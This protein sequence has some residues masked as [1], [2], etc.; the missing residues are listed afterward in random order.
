MAS[1]EAVYNHV[2]LPPKLPGHQDESIDDANHAQLGS[3]SAAPSEPVTALTKDVSRRNRCWK[4]STIWNL[5]ACSSST[6]WSRTRPS[7]FD[8]KQ[9]KYSFPQTIYRAAK[10]KIS[11]LKP[12]SRSGGRDAI[13]F[14]AFEASPSSVNVLAAEGVLLWDFPGRAAELPLEEFSSESFQ[15]CL[16]QFLELA[17][18]ESLQ[19]FA[20]HS[21]KADVFVIEA[22][23]TTDP[24]LVTQMLMP[25]LESLGAPASV[26]V[27][28]KR[29]RDDVN[30]QGAKLPWRRLPFWLVLR[31]AT[32]RHLRLAVGDEA[33]QACYKF[34]ICTLLAQILE[35]STAQLTPEQIITA[36]AKLCRRLAK[37]EMDRAASA[38]SAFDELFVSTGPLLEGSIEKATAEVEAAWSSFKKENTRPVSR[39]PRHADEVALR[40]SLRN[41][42]T[43]LDDLLR[44]QTARQNIPSAPLD[45]AGVNDDA[46]TKESD[47]STQR[48]FDLSELE[49][50]IEQGRQSVPDSGGSCEY[51]CREL[52][53]SIANLFTEVGTAYD[54][55]PEQMSLFILNVFDMW[56]EMDECAVKTCPLLA[57]FHPVFDPG[58]LDVVQAPTRSSMRRLLRIQNHLQARCEMCRFPD[59]TI[60]SPLDDDCFA[61]QYLEESDRL[62]DLRRRVD[63]ASKRCRS[64]KEREWRAACSKYDNLSEKISARTCVCSFYRDGTRD[65]RGCTK[66]WHWRT[67][68]KLQISIHEEFLP[69]AAGQKAGVLFELGM[70]KYLERYRNV[71]WKIVRDLA[72]PGGPA[73]SKPPVLLLK[74]CA[75]LKPFADGLS[76]SSGISLAS[77]KKSFLQT[78]FKAVKM[79]VDLHNILFPMGALFSL[80]DAES[81]T[82]LHRL[83]KPLTL[84]HLCGVHVPRG[85]QDSVLP[86]SEHPPRDVDGP[87]SYEIVAS[88]TN[89]PSKMT[90]H[91]FMAYQRLF[92]GKARRWFTILVELGS[93]NLNFSS[94]DTMHVLGQ[95]AVQAGPR[96]GREPLRVAHAVFE[97]DSFCRRLAEQ[98]NT[99]LRGLLSN[100]R[101]SHCM[102]LLITLSLRLFALAPSTHRKSAEGMLK[103]ARRATCE[104]ISLLR[105]EVRNATEADAA[106]R[107][108]T[109]GLWA[110][111]LCRRTFA[112]FVEQGG[113]SPLGPEDLCAY[114]QASIALRENLITNVEKL[115]QTLKNLLVRDAKLAHG[116]EDLI[117]LSANSCPGSLEAAIT[118]SWSGSGDSAGR[119][120]SPWKF[121]PSPNNSW[122]A[123][124]ITTTAHRFAS[125]QV[126]HF[127]F[128]QGHLLVD[129]N[130]LGKLP[131][132]IRNSEAVRELFGNQHLLTYSSSL[133]DMTHMLA[134]EIQGH[135]I[136]FGIR[137]DS[138]VIR[139]VTRHG[140]LEYVP[141]RVFSMMNDGFDL[142]TSLVDNCVQW[143][144][145]HSKRIEFRRKPVIW[146]TRKQDWILDV[147]NRQARRARVLLVDPH[148][149]LFRR[150]ARLFRHFEVP[151]RLTAF[152]PLMGTLSLE[153]RHLELSFFVNRDSL[154]ECRELRAEIDPDQD[155][156]TMYGLDS[157]IVLRD[158]DNKGRRSLIVPLSAPT[159]RRHGV[160]IAVRACGSSNYGRFEID[161]ILGRLSCPPEPVLLY[162]KALLHA[163]TSFALPDPLTGRTGTE[164]AIHILKSGSSQPWTPLGD[165]PARIL[166]TLGKLSPGR[167]Y[168]P[169]DK[170]C[171]QTVDWSENL[172]ATIQHDV[173]ESIVEQ[174]LNKSDRLEAFAS[175]RDDEVST[176]SPSHLRKRGESQR[177]LYERGGSDWEGSLTCRDVRYE[178]R[179]RDLS[180]SQ[181][182]NVCQIVGL[183]RKR[184][185]KI[186]VKRGIEA[187]LRHWK[188]IGGFLDPGN[189]APVCM[190]DLVDSDLSEQWGALINFCKSTDLENP[191]PLIFRLSALSFGPD[192]NMDM[193]RVLVAFGCLEE[194]RALP[195]P[196]Y[197]SFV[198]LKTSRCPTAE[199]LEG[200]IASAYVAFTCATPKKKVRQSR[201][202]HR[203]LCEA[204]G[205]RLARF[206]AEQWPTSRPLVEGFRSSV[207]DVDL[208]LD[209][210]LPEWDR[211]YRNHALVEYTREAQKILDCYKGRQ[212]MSTVGDVALNGPMMHRATRD[213]VVPSLSRHLLTKCGPLPGG[214][215]SPS[216]GGVVA[217]DALPRLGSGSAAFGGAPVSRASA[218]SPSEAGEL[219]RILDLFI[220]SPD[221]LRRE[222]GL[223]LKTSLAALEHV[224]DGQAS[225]HRAPPSL[226]AINDG[227][228][229]ASAA[230]NRHFGS[231]AAAFS[232]ADCR[233]KWLRLGNMWPCITPVTTLELL[234]STSGNVFGENMKEALVSY[235]LLATY[236]QRLERMAQA[237]LRREEPK[238]DAEWRNGGHENWVP[239]DFPDWLLIEIDSNLLIRSEQVDVALAIILPPSGSNS[240][241]QMNMGQGKTSCIV[242]MAMAL[243]ASKTQ[244][245]RLIVPKALLLQTAQMVQSRLG[246][247]VGREVRSIS[248]SRQTPTTPTMLRLYSEIHQEVLGLHGLILA[249]PDHILSFKLSGLQKVADSKM[250]AAQ[251]MIRIQ[252]WLTNTC[253]D[254]LDE[255]DF[256]LGARTQLIYPS[257]P[258]THVDGHP[259]RWEVAQSLLHLV[260]DGLPSLRSRFPRS[261]EVVRR[262][263]GFPIVHF[264]NE[265]VENELHR[266]I[267]NT[268]CS[269][270]SS[271]LRFARPSTV[272]QRRDME[273]LLCDEILDKAA[274]DRSLRIFADQES[275]PKML[276]LIR[277]LVLNRILLLCL[278]K[279]WNVQYGLHPDRPP[280]AV[281]F[282]AKGVPS[283]RAE[284]GHPDVAIIFTCL[285][286]YYSGLT[287][288]QFSQALQHVLNS[289][290]PATEY[291]RWTQGCDALPDALHHWNA[292]NAADK[293][294]VEELWHHLRL[295]RTVLGYYMNRFV[296]PVHAK[297][298]GIKLQASAWDLPLFHQSDWEGEGREPRARTSGFSGTNDNKIMLPLTIQQDD[299]P[300]LRQTNAEVLTYLLQNRNRGYQ[301]ASLR[302]RR[303]TEDELL[304]TIATAE[305]R[306]LIDAGAYILEMDNP[307]L[308]EAW[309]KFDTRA[310]AAVFFGADNRAWVKYRGESKTVPL[311]A[312]PLA[313][314]LEECLVYLDEAHTRGTDLKLPKKARGALTLALGQTKDHTVQAAMRLRQL[315]TTQSVTFYAPPEV[316]QSILDVCKPRL[317]DAIRSAHVIEWLLEQTCRANEQLQNLYIAQGA[318]FCRRTNA[319]W[320]NPSFTTDRAQR[321]A[322]LGII[323]QPERQTLEQQYG[324][325]AASRSLLPSEISFA[326]LREFMED[327]GRQRRAADGQ[328]LGI[329]SSALEEVEQERE[330]EMQIEEIRQAEK[331]EKYE[332]LAFPGLHS[333]VL[334]FV[335]TGS[336]RGREGY[337][338]AFSA[339][340]DTEIGRKYGVCDTGSR[341]FVSTE[342]TRTVLASNFSGNR[343]LSD[344][345]SLQRPVEW[346]LWSP[347]AETALVIIPEEAELL[348]PVIRKAGNRAKTHLVA[349]AAPVTKSMLHFNDLSFCALPSLPAGRSVPAWLSRELGIFSGRLYVGFAE[350]AL[351]T[352]YLEVSMGIGESSDSPLPPPNR[353]LMPVHGDRG[354]MFATN[355]AGFLAEWLTLR[356]KAQDIMH[357]PMGYICQGRPLHENHP[358]FLARPCEGQETI[359]PA[360]ES[361]GA[362][363]D[364]DASEDESLEAETSNG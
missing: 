7:S 51:R 359:E 40:L 157:K 12:N 101:E 236:L 152:Q 164:E 111:L 178:S 91:E 148:S 56:V 85:L 193:I 355:P 93:S 228:E 297:Q 216:L 146:K 342:F 1:L 57:K 82:W 127:N 8:A 103:A 158:V 174:I 184:P 310:K 274:L 222:Y 78:H 196:P 35:D 66:C 285:A 48:Y 263:R 302:G 16:A 204:E 15:H 161:N 38:C 334:S 361:A 201:E 119:T 81:G 162:S 208:A 323:Q 235:A 151:E 115:P 223:D 298:F 364:V 332:A 198:E 172:T 46:T 84:Q 261:I 211:V 278:K 344:D 171:L 308:A 62:Q 76:A 140:L 271:F 328:A 5:M 97:D 89:C 258:Q 18:I 217:N 205:R 74:D 43:Y 197:P 194:L 159:W 303:M 307:T 160:H 267:I 241:L 188:F 165:M 98:I 37:L 112:T 292:I 299:L 36:R 356:R 277:G 338:Q 94:E 210:L 45:L 239:F 4:H 281:P 191:Y 296:F 117:A 209:K 233:F 232:A 69:G 180:L 350:Y 71:T 202:N 86:P 92:S 290:D 24:A 221:R 134:T 113:R 108:A 251:E 153:L 351:L 100:W 149:D 262:Q 300:S 95:L 347:S 102:E 249:T 226:P 47:I 10:I 293:G 253:R 72:H 14:E 163:L 121:L 122:L 109:Y 354:R 125:Y 256:T 175:N 275:A 318:D 343:H 349:H 260:E 118:M 190:S 348:I 42:G 244:L 20:A 273:R 2:V 80:Y 280:V 177:L 124:V 322:F 352:T 327:L 68:K 270:R 128:V 345:D 120:F 289:D 64:Q 176:R 106:E 147:P 358:F 187:G 59:K 141:P 314:N 186:H 214:L 330:V 219:G 130:P 266:R 114:F 319:Q 340:G 326:K 79:K 246:G 295:E 231:L 70:P 315:G 29:I 54:S 110:A 3:L 284:F 185:F 156:G 136:H 234:R 248:F 195:T 65:V 250:D 33:G 291:D 67:R 247:L 132:S 337:M 181:A 30:I 357:T 166:Q 21:V 6:S 252:S 218:T 207:I 363:S 215:L 116:L 49:S 22:R 317:Q 200:F 31:V 203:L 26:P 353:E 73:P 39:L 294:Q 268:V 131:L 311:M 139:A 199:M 52:A 341:F 55:N 58:L 316:H 362:G 238:L 154:F 75:Q 286:F 220:K 264:L 230:I 306:V 41:S 61:A 335:E 276:L 138:V 155:A 23:G 279:R 126:V 104:W 11:D 50:R 243:L 28:R 329:Q 182:A 167:E 224:G 240:V 321:Q 257:G 44:P 90:I 213:A 242:P 325:A 63:V 168:Y 83:N 288:D 320:E 99:R 13:I 333:S 339:L 32:Q 312:T 225:L 60:L 137:G 287:L 206:V 88:Q 133:P 87:S 313:D 96:D 135:Q 265:D 170:R 107:A 123:S 305:I 150:V 179:C 192:P 169:R 309:L 254:V 336:L 34:L 304:K 282:E 259:H 25:L 19:R 144:N 324:A 269:G 17:S 245:P 27:L 53:N 229:R 9:G 255:S 77:S 346:I 145:L 227:I 105:R 331:P 142:P 283:E 143:L 212:E 129:G 173:L 301:V 272:K 237:H 360:V 189:P 183:I